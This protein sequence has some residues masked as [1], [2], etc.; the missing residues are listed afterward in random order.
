VSQAAAPA[1]VHIVAVA[2]NGVIGSAGAL[3][4][5]LKS[6]MAHFRAITMGKPIV[7]GRKTWQS[8]PRKPLSGR[9][10]IVVTRDPSF[11]APGALVVR[12]LAA[13]LEAARGDALRRGSDIA[14]IGGA[15]IFNAT[16]PVTD[17]VEFTRVHASPPGDTY[18]P[19]L[20]AADWRSVAQRDH[21]AGPGDDVAYSVHTYERVSRIR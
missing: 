7:M 8:L 16:L 21:P 12:S 11:T 6:E 3:P 9:T 19:D 2:E 5:R 13:A 20:P 17:R 10:N 1:I 14:I 18:F 15:D 4:W